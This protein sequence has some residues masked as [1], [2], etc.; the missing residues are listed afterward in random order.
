MAR[1]ILAYTNLFEGRV[2]VTE[3]LTLDYSLLIEM[4]KL[5]NA[6][7]EARNKQVKEQ[8]KQMDR[9]TA[10]KPRK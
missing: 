8:Q 5:K 7:V 10:M 3:I 2:S 6:E 1:E 9:N 4:I